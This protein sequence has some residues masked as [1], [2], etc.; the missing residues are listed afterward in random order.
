MAKRR[1]A[2]PK[3]PRVQIYPDKDAPPVEQQRMPG[4]V[5]TSGGMYLNTVQ[6]PLDAY[7][8]K[9]PGGINAAQHEAGN[10]LYEIFKAGGFDSVGRSFLDRLNDPV[11]DRSAVVGGYTE[12]Q[13]DCMRALMR[14]MQAVNGA[15]GK[16]VIRLVV[17]EGYWLKELEVQTYPRPSEMM[18]RFREALDD[19][20][21][22]FHVMVPPELKSY[23]DLRR[24]VMKEAKNI[25][26]PI[27]LTLSG[28]PEQGQV[29][30]HIAFGRPVADPRLRHG[31][32][33]DMER[34]IHQFAVQRASDL[35]LAA[36]PKIAF[37]EYN[38]TANVI[39]LR[40]ITATWKSNLSHAALKNIG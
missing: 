23:Y 14:A 22:H 2:R 37:D 32:K 3:P 4:M 25:D 5:R 18:A 28:Q 21:D 26:Y 15:V 12:H 39:A 34:Y 19:L 30:L 9:K 20:V 16:H 8:K 24:N 13:I 36:A 10:R 1:K 11:V 33:Q 6:I 40:S 38:Q 31:Y 29:Q 27:T 7:L 17:L 35:L